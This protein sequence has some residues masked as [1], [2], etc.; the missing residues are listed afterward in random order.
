MKKF[1][2]LIGTKRR[3]QK[4]KLLIFG[5]F[6]EKYW[7]KQVELF[8][9]LRKNGEMGFFCIVQICKNEQNHG[10][11][12]FFKNRFPQVLVHKKDK[13]EVFGLL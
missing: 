6:W 12:D 7:E 4:Q 1:F 9:L 13:Y 8:V 5:H 10:I 11:F 3:Y 2:L